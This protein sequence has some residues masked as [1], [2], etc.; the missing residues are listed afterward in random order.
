MNRLLL[1]CVALFALGG[2]QALDGAGA[3]MASSTVGGLA[4]LDA[5]SVINTH[6]TVDDHIVSMITGKD[7]STVRASMG[8]YY[9]IEQPGNVPTI[10]RTSYCYKTLAK[11]SCYTQP[12]EADAG[13][14]YGTRVDYIPVKTH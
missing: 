7:C 4:V 3:T 5:V 13:E 14:F 2:C 12:V 9:C 8:D 11:V 6:K 10:V 1:S